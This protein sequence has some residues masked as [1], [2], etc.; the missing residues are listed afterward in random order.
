[1]DHSPISHFK[2][3]QGHKSIKIGV[4]KFMCMGASPPLDHPHVFI[5]MGKEDKK[6][7]P[8]CSTLYQF[9]S[10]LN[11]EETIPAGNFISI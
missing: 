1:M 4:K 2:N 11:S 3:D 8:Y 6:H 5:N 7:C 10:S 9:D